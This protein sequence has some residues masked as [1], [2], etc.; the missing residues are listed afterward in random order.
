MSAC[1]RVIKSQNMY[2][3]STIRHAL[4]SAFY[5]KQ[6]KAD[7]GEGDHLTKSE[8]RKYFS[9]NPEAETGSQDWRFGEAELHEKYLSGLQPSVNA[10]MAVHWPLL[11]SANGLCLPKESC[12]R[13]CACRRCTCPNA[14]S[15]ARHVL[16]LAARKMQSHIVPHNTLQHVSCSGRSGVHF[17]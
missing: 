11:L 10:D 9:K 7:E 14:R 3:G 6:M 1:V 12:A 17:A 15:S 8:S 16:S 5:V 2:Q 4:N 13:T